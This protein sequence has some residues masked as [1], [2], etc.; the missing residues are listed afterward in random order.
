M[1]AELGLRDLGSV[2]DGPSGGAEPSQSNRVKGLHLEIQEEEE[3]RNQNIPTDIRNELYT[4]DQGTIRSFSPL[5]L[6][7]A[8]TYQSYEEL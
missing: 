6:N 1:M 2:K 5:I 7:T 4:R 3:T 8:C